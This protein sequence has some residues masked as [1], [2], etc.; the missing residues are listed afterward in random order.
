[1]EQARQ[2]YLSLLNELSGRLDQL[3]ELA[4]QKTQAVKKDDLTALDEAL[5]QEDRK[6]V[7]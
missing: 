7:V 2:A 6:S 4:R 1:M 5:K 3:S